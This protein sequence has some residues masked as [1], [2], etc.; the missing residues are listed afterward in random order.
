MIQHT[1]GLRRSIALETIAR[2][3]ALVVSLEQRPP[4]RE[5]GRRVDADRSN[6]Q[7]DD[8]DKRR[9]RPII[10]DRQSG[11]RK[12]DCDGGKSLKIGIGLY[13]IVYMQMLE[14]Q[15]NNNIMTSH[16]RTNP[17]DLL[18]ANQQR[19]PNALLL[20]FRSNPR[21]LPTIIPTTRKQPRSSSD[22]GKA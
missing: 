7:A 12:D 9:G 19:T 17:W 2:G 4:Y 8:D 18:R 10:V 21:R 20:F 16:S 15:Y 3:S 6:D 11:F 1:T 5:Q 14:L 13:D 22:R